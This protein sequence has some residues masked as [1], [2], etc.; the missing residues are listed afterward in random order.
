MCRH[1]QG[2]DD[3]VLDLSDL[4]ELVYVHISSRA[5]TATTALWWMRLVESGLQVQQWL[6]VLLLEPLQL[7][8]MAF[9]DLDAPK[10]KE[11][12]TCYRIESITPGTCR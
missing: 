4:R 3:S 7:R 2:L 12:G 1:V 11:D 6:V 8:A 5:E 10:L 9:L